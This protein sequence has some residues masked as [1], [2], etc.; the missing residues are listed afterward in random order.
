MVYSVNSVQILF[1]HTSYAGRCVMILEL[2]ME[3]MEAVTFFCINRL[4]VSKDRLYV[5][6]VSHTLLL[7]TLK[8]KDLQ[9]VIAF[10]EM[11]ASILLKLLI[12][13]KYFSQNL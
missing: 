1:D 3:S 6:G 2:C 12:E 5:P 8:K 11:F 13:G 9:F 10:F 4:Q 7:H